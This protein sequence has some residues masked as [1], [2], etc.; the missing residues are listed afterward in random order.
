MENGAWMIHRFRIGQTVQL[1]RNALRIAN[2][3][4][5]RILALRPSDGNDPLYLVKSDN[6]RHQRIVPQSAMRTPLN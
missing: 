6:E 1:T 3:T 2:D 5:F 4:Y